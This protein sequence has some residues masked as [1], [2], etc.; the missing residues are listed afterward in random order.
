METT[1]LFLAGFL[2]LSFI[3]CSD[4]IITSTEIEFPE[5]LYPYE[6][7]FDLPTFQQRRNDFIKMIHDNGIA[8]ITTNDI[9]LR[10]GDVDYEFRPASTFFYLTGFEEPN[11]VAVIRKMSADPNTAELIMFVEER[12]G[13]I[14]QH[15]LV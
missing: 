1:K 13:S 6:T 14:T 8:V 7:F 12:E 11:A 2:I 10:N 3:G 5:K 15:F 4:D 9:Y